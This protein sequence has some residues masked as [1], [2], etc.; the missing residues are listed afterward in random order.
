MLERKRP[1]LGARLH[2]ARPCSV[3]REATRHLH[4]GPDHSRIAVRT[5]RP[6]APV[7][8][9]TIRPGLSRGKR[10]T[11]PPSGSQVR[12][13]ETAGLVDHA[14]L[15]GNHGVDRQ[16][17][18]CTESREH[19]EPFSTLDARVDVAGVVSDGADTPRSPHASSNCETDERA[20]L[21]GVASASANAT[22][23]RRS[24]GFEAT[25]L[26]D[27]SV[28]RES[29]EPATNPLCRSPRS[30]GRP[31][32]FRQARR[33]IP[34]VPVLRGRRQEPRDHEDHGPCSASHLSL[35]FLFEKNLTRSVRDRRT[36]RRRVG[37]RTRRYG[38]R[39]LFG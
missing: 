36:I 11:A 35:L 10:T 24:E 26:Q 8:R 21:Q 5:G 1:G 19:R 15:S 22:N 6:Q 32:C 39:Y 2:A 4:D 9:R 7:K 13:L 20:V 23:I 14:H 16:S 34:Q 27:E 30:V 31:V 29:L 37:S 17:D 12:P 3:P 38:P 18:Q 28:A 33:T 25:C